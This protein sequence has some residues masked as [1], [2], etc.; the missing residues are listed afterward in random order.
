MSQYMVLDACSI[1]VKYRSNRV[2]AKYNYTNTDDVCKMSFSGTLVT[3]RGLN[4][5]QNQ[6]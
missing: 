4:E 3:D 2:R 1:S 5:V 6:T